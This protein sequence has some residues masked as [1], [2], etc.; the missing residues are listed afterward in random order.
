MSDK[1]NATIGSAA[2]TMNGTLDLAMARDDR[3]VSYRG[4]ATLAHVHL[5]DRATSESVLRWHS[6]RA[7]D[8]DAEMGEGLPKVRI[9]ALALNGFDGRVILNADGRLNVLDMM[10]SPRSAPTPLTGAQP[11]SGAQTSATSS[12]PAA[13]FASPIDAE[14]ELGGM[15]LQDGHVT[16]TDNF[17][18]PNYT[19]DLSALAGTVGPFGT[20]ATAPAAV[21]L[22][23]QV[24][25][26]APIAIT[27]SVNPLAPM[28]FVDLKAKADG[29]E[30][31]GLT[32]YS[33]KY[34]GYQIV[35]G[36]LT[37]DVHYLL[38][39]GQLTADNHL[40]IDQFSFG[41]RVE[42]RD[43][44]TLPVRLAVALLK[45]AR[46]EIDVDVPVSGSLSDP[47]F[48]LSGVI[49]DA[50]VNFIVKVVTSPFSLIAS[51]FGTQE[52]LD[53]IEF[54]P[55]LA[56]LTPDSQHKL[57]TIA[58]ALQDRPA[59]QLD[60]SG[61]V[62]PQVDREGLR[63][64][65]LESLIRMQKIKNLGG[66][67]DPD[68]VQLTPEEYETYLTRVY[69]M[70][71]FPKPRNLLGLDTSRPPAEMKAL[72]LT[73]MEITDQDL[74]DLADGRAHAVRQWLSGQVDP[75]RLFV[76]APTLNT[77]GDKD[78]RKTTRV[79]LSLK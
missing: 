34:T 35:K 27:G 14:I 76:V 7:S 42:S 59:L 52:D 63:E 13:T 29:V 46:G 44:T 36:T 69:K 48:S 5:L 21:A 68:R 31:A 18:K 25:G 6:C 4:D 3:R 12:V 9:G 62:D 67:E 56:T 73:H 47:Q 2:L 55:G 64:A 53:S 60:I 39:Q 32:P 57:V 33:A 17:I 79:D 77:D 78:K 26:R 71:T 1:L 50:F 41:D 16:F 74:Q 11:A 72:L 37:I 65:K 24:N 43:A 20:R 45:N 10:A 19:A 38:D 75:G 15:T 70:A 51:A 54:A 8:I 23:G 49:L 66:H 30:L 22:Q 58:Q 40:F 28:A 61:R